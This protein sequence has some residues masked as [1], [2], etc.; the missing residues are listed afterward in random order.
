[1]AAGLKSEGKGLVIQHFLLSV[2]HKTNR[3][4]ESGV[5]LSMAQL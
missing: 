4:D 2:N 1:M 5:N 3:V